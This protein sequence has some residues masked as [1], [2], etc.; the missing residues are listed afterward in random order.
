MVKTPMIKLE[1]QQADIPIE[2]TPVVELS[3]TQAKQLMKSLRPPPSDKQKEHMAK[4]VEKNRLKWQQQ[5][6]EKMKKIEEE[7]KKKQETHQKVIIKPKRIYKNALVKKLPPRIQEEPEY[8][9]EDEEHEEEEEIIEVVKPK[10]KIIKKIIREESDEED[11]DDHLIQKTKKAT[12]II[13]TVNKLDSAINT[14]KTNNNK[15]S[16]MLS[17][18]KF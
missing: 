13:E 1:G 12:K 3:Y 10:K 4:L 16:D 5:K 15:Y 7:E 6:E 2:N 9:D 17:K 8:D 14:L 18:I 11:D